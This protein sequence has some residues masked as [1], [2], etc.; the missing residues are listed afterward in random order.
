LSGETVEKNETL[1]QSCRYFGS[2][3]N[4]APLQYNS[5]ALQIRSSTS[6]RRNIVF[7]TFLLYLYRKM[8]SGF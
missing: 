1:S 7:G 6:V 2:D 4:H 3:S 5:V 8:G